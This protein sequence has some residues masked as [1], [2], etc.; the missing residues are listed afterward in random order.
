MRYG[1][2]ILDLGPGRNVELHLATR[3][4]GAAIDLQAGCLAKFEHGTAISAFAIVGIRQSRNKG[5]DQAEYE[6]SRTHG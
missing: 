1:A 6:H 4:I 2:T 3:E 5:H